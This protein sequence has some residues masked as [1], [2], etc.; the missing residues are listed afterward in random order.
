MDSSSMVPVNGADGHEFKGDVRS[1]RPRSRVHCVLGGSAQHDIMDQLGLS[2][3]AS[4]PPTQHAHQPKP[5]LISHK[6]PHSFP[7]LSFQ[8]TM[9]F[10]SHP[11]PS[12]PKPSASSHPPIPLE[13]SSSLSV[14]SLRS[15]CS[16]ETSSSL[17]CE[18]LV[19][20]LRRLSLSDEYH[21]PTLRTRIPG[22]ESFLPFV[23]QER[24]DTIRKATQQVMMDKEHRQEQ[25]RMC[26]DID[27]T[28]SRE[29]EPSHTTVVTLWGRGVGIRSEDGCIPTM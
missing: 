12:P 2:G 7:P 15:L 10:A 16:S 25:R 13:P 5:K 8:P 29:G 22:A 17:E 23:S 3:R 14:S 27:V 6:Q 19:S 4:C 20:P 21:S 28:P 26:R 9:P 1:C 11:S 24:P 18:G